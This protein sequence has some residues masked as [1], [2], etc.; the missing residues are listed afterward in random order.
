MT[1]PEPLNWVIKTIQD[2]LEIS[3]MGDKLLTISL[4]DFVDAAND[5]IPKS[6]LKKALRLLEEKK[7]IKLQD[8]T[9]LNHVGRRA[10]ETVSFAIDRKL[11]DKFYKENHGETPQVKELTDDEV[12]YEVAYN[13]NSREITINGFLLSKPD[14]DSENDIF[15]SYVFTH[16]NQKLRMEKIQQVN[17]GKPFKKAVHRIIADLGFSGEFA[18]VF[19]NAS[20]R[21]VLFR[22]KISKKDLRGLGIERLK[23]QEKK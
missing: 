18:K 14:F 23:I 6:D 22:N 11:F 15:A 1:L 17:G 8:I 5:T 12:I 13:E 16:P 2:K 7:L 9:S 20:R 19:F 3:P 4:W 10:G 21:A